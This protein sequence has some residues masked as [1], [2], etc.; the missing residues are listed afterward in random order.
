[1]LTDEEVQRI[2]AEENVRFAIR[3]ELAKSLEAPKTEST[4][5]KFLNSTLGLWLLSAVFISLAGGAFTYFQQQHAEYL[6]E[7]DSIERLDL[8]LGPGRMAAQR[9]AR[10]L[11]VLRSASQWPGLGAIPRPGEAALV[12]G[13]SAPQP[14]AQGH[15]GADGPSGQPVAAQ[16][17]N[18]SSSSRP[19][20]ARHYPRQ[21]PSAVAPL[22]G[23]C[24][25]G[26]GQPASLPRLRAERRPRV[27]EEEE[28]P[29]P[30]GAA[31][32]SAGNGFVAAAPPGLEGNW[33][34]P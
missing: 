21:E 14:E 3:T 17:A 33:G 23:I 18:H 27:R 10:P 30:S 16:S 6:K 25:G 11:P 9:A 22:A 15:L 24:A 28:F 1:M 7:R 31:E 13:A 4:L 5:W 26:A 29:S 2:R 19:T 12:Y 34:S 32:T 8:E 20:S